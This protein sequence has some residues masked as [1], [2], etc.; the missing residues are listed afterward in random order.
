MESIYYY[1]LTLRKTVPIFDYDI[2]HSNSLMDKYE[3]IIQYIKNTYADTYVKYIYEI[4]GKK[5]R[6]MNLH[7]H[8][9]LRMPYPYELVSIPRQKGMSVHFEEC[10]EALAWETYI[11]K[12]PLT[13]DD[14]VSRVHDNIRAY[15]AEE[16]RDETPK[17]MRRIV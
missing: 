6:S 4:V 12:E 8:A 5:N 3:N 17:I 7:L 15:R 14:V 2:D 10:N 11:S 16:Y 9:I 1:A 13:R